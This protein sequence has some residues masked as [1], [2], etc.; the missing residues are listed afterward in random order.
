MEKEEIKMVID[1]TCSKSGIVSTLD[2]KV[3]NSK[4]ILL[5]G[6]DIEIIRLIKEKELS[7]DDL[8]LILSRLAIDPAYLNIRERKPYSRY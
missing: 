3:I 7:E 2:I 4:V 6:D 5:R 8:I 1:K